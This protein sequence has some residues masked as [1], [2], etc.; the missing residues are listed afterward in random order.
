MAKAWLMKV[1]VLPESKRATVLLPPIVMKTQGLEDFVEAI[2][3]PLVVSQ[4]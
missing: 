1:D 2:P 3:P 4:P